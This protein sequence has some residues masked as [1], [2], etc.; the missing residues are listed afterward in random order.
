VI[1]VFTLHSEKS[2]GSPT[3]CVP[4][5]GLFSLSWSVNWQT[6]LP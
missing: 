1:L 2:C 3:N 5:T 6:H 4:L